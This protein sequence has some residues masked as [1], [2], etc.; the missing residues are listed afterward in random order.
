MVGLQ[1]SNLFR[2]T[3]PSLRLFRYLLAMG[4]IDI[5]G[6]TEVSIDGHVVQCSLEDIGRIF[7]RTFSNWRMTASYDNVWVVVQNATTRNV[8]IYVVS[9]DDRLPD[10]GMEVMPPGASFVFGFETNAFRSNTQFW[11]H[12]EFMDGNAV[13][14]AD[15]D[16]YGNR[17]TTNGTSPCWKLAVLSD[18]KLCCPGYEMNW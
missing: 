6:G 11:A 8:S 5:G 4:S 17:A 1:R 9:G 13:R 2:T 12:A 18:D 16:V 7:L 10:G 15:F 14:S 3:N